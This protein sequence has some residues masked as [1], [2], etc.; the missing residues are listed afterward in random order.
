MANFEKEIDRR[1]TFCT[2]WDFVQ[3]RFSIP[4]LLPFT[5]SDTDFEMPEE[6]YEALDQRL[7]HKV[8]GYTRWNHHTFKSSITRWYEKRFQFAL[9]EA[10]VVYSPTVMYSISKLI[11]LNSK[12]GSG[13]IIQTPAY[14]AFFKTIDSNHRKI[15]ENP[16]V[17]EGDYY[18]IDFADLE[19]KLAQ[20]ENEILLLCSPHNPTGRV[21][22]DEELTKIVQLCQTYGVF[23]LS[24]EI[25]MD[26]LRKGITHYPILKYVDTNVALLSSGSKTFNF[27]G[28]VFSYALIPDEGLREAFQICLKNQDGL[29]SASTLGMVGTMTAYNECGYWVDELNDYI[30][31]N[32]DYVKEYLH[33]K[34]PEIVI[35]QS[36]STYLMWLN[37]KGLGFD[38]QELQRVMTE[39]GKV[40]IMDGRVYGGDGVD[41]IRLNVGCTRTKLTEGLNR[42]E[43]SIRYLKGLGN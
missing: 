41:F 35:N 23:I 18:K 33:K 26:V 8:F 34:L 27:P 6:V 24:D 14:D 37:I 21:W 43:K 1:G 22:T 11:Q 3:D 31:G 36:E 13:V 20:P 10:S 29:S 38:M 9:K 2:Q 7:K 4:N 17:N 32:I 12:E 5:I 42:L 28:L 40:A 15:V 25:H 30:D 19:G 39:Y 16:L